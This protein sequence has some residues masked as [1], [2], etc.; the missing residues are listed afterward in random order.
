MRTALVNFYIECTSPDKGQEVLEKLLNSNGFAFY[1]ATAA[2]SLTRHRD[3]GSP[4]LYTTIE[5]VEGVL[6]RK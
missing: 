5:H 6:D 4:S 3:N 1:D 2:D